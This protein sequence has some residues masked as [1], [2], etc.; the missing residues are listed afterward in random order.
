M[1]ISVTNT[2]LLA[3]TA[4]RTKRR[5]MSSVVIGASHSA[6]AQAAWA[7]VKGL[8]L[9]GN[10]TADT[11]V[12][13]FSFRIRNG[14]GTP[15]DHS[16]FTRLMSDHYGIQA[17]GGCACAGP[18]GHRL[19]GIDPDTSAHMAEDI[20]HGHEVDKPGWVRVNLSYLLTDAKADQILHEAVVATE[21]TVRDFPVRQLL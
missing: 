17:R 20:R 21:R 7:G 6:S 11:R 19:L 4:R 15:V 9:L 16:A 18:Y 3:N 12:P 8:D 1:P 14:Q 13:I 10:S 2:E 5:Y